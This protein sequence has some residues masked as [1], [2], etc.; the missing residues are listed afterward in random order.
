MEIAIIFVTSFVIAMSGAMMPGPLLTATISE[1]A[2]RGA[3]AGP[4]IVLGHGILEFAL[5]VALYLGL[6]PYLANDLTVGIVAVVGCAILL[7]MAWCMFRSLPSL[8]LAIKPEA[9]QG[10]KAIVAKGVLLSLANP[11]WT[12]WWATIGLGY[13]LSSMKQGIAGLTAFYVGHILADLAFYAAVSIAIHKGKGLMSD[14]LYRGIV[15]GCAVMLVVFAIYFGY[16]G[17]AKLI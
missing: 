13:I 15:G 1:S 2:Q 12:V 4:L 10:G 6:A 11:Y 16:S 7:W 17:C 5:V 8:T 14:R 9:M 3:W